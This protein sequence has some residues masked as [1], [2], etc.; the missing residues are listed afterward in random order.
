MNKKYISG[1]FDCCCCGKRNKDAEWFFSKLR[2]VINRELDKQVD[3]PIQ[4]LKA[5]LFENDFCWCGGILK[6][7]FKSSFKT[8]LISRLNNLTP[9]DNVKEAIFGKKRE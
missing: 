3:N 9:V 4:R 5:V 1:G 7:E 6:P 2:R 8:I